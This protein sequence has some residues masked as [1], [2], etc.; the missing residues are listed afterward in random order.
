[1]KTFSE[2]PAN[3]QRI[4][5]I[6]CD[7]SGGLNLVQVS[8]TD[9]SKHIAISDP[10]YPIGTLEQHG[11]VKKVPQEVRRGGKYRAN[12]YKILKRVEE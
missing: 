8:K 3:A 1:M 4:Y 11:F 9:I 6:L 5:K 7:L 10:F 12:V 2:L